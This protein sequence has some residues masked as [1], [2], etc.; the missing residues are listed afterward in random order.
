MLYLEFLHRPIQRIQLV[1]QPPVD[2]S[3]PS[4][5][6]AASKPEITSKVTEPPFFLFRAKLR[7]EES[8]VKAKAAQ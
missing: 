7:I 5:G 6:S 1:Y 8:Q 2:F 3:H 4:V